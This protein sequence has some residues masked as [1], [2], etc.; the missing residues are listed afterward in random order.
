[1]LPWVTRP[2]TSLES[3]FLKYQTGESLKQGGGIGLGSANN[4]AN[5]LSVEVRFAYSKTS[6]QRTCWDG[7]FVPCREAVLFSDVLF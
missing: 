4:A 5:L 2:L 1:M 3:R 7:A 6:E